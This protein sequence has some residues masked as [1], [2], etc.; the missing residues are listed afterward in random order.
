MNRLL[1]VACILGVLIALVGV[2]ISSAVIA[3]GSMIAVPCYCAL[4]LRR[5]DG[6]VQP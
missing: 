2:L 4:L 3:G 1:L 5:I 6:K